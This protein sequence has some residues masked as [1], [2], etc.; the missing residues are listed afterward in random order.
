M[1]LGVAAGRCGFA[2]PFCSR[3]GTW[4]RKLYLYISSGRIF[5]VLSFERSGC[6]SARTVFVSIGRFQGRTERPSGFAGFVLPVSEPVRVR[7]VAPAWQRR[8]SGRRGWRA[9]N[10]VMGS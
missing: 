5:A 7:R 6:P 10:S 9:I 1:L 3:L 4:G 8:Q 2:M